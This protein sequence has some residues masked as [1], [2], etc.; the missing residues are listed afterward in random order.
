MLV[1]RSGN[2]SESNA[3]AHVSHES[4]FRKIWGAIESL[5]VNVADRTVGSGNVLKSQEVL[6]VTV[7]NRYNVLNSHQNLS[8]DNQDKQFCQIPWTTDKDKEILC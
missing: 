6:S 4:K 1:N 2:K 8:D 5:R 3:N 7:A